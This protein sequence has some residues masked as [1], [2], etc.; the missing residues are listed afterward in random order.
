MQALFGESSATSPI[1][2][3]LSG[4]TSAA[5]NATGALSN[6]DS[7]LADT[8]DT[9]KSTAKEMNKLLGGFDEINSLSDS[10]ASGG[11]SITDFQIDF[12]DGTS[13][14]F[15]ASVTTTVAGAKVNDALTFSA[16][17]T[18]STNI[19]VTNPTV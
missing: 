13:F 9:A 1:T 16:A 18:L 8:G 10:G 19:A 6:Y 14:A 11:G 4:T 3:T 12:P 5:N 2:N 7:T 17:M 15:S